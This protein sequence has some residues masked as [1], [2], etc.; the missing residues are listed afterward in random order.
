MAAASKIEA[1][2][3]KAGGIAIFSK[4]DCPYCS[5][6]KGILSAYSGMKPR[7]QVLELNTMG[8]EGQAIQDALA[9]KLGKGRVTVPQVFIGGKLVGGCD[10]LQAAQSNGTLNKLLEELQ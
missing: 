7:L 9:K 1:I 6:A 4:T 2:I 10:A 5:R 8:S 3:G